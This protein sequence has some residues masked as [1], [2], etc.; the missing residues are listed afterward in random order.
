LVIDGNLARAGPPR[1]AKWVLIL[2]HFR[3]SFHNRSLFDGKDPHVSR[4]YHLS[5]PAQAGYFEIEF[6][7]GEFGV[8]S[9]QG[10]ELTLRGTS[11]EFEDSVGN[12]L[13]L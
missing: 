10:L 4:N 13:P 9:H 3:Y 7:P 5:R 11:E 1:A 6:I 2:L 12:E 8:A